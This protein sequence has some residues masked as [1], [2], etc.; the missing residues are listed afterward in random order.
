MCSRLRILAIV[1]SAVVSSFAA[2]GQGEVQIPP[3]VFK[4][5]DTFE[6]HELSKADTSFNAK[7]YR[8]SLKEYDAFIVEFPRSAAVPYAILR[9]GRSLQ[10]DDKRYDAIKQYDEIMDYFPNDVTYAAPALYYTGLAYWESADNEEA[11]KAWAEMAEDK[12]YRQHIFAADAINRLAGY[13]ASL[14]LHDKALKYFRQI[15]VDFRHRSPSAAA[16]AM[17]RV[18]AYYMQRLDEPEL[19]KF[20]QDTGTFDRF[21]KVPADLAD[22]GPYWHKVLDLIRRYGSFPDVQKSKRDEY[23]RYWVAQLGERFPADDGYRVAIINLQRIYEADET[24]WVER[25]DKQFEDHQKSDNW[26]RVLTWM[27]YLS[28]HKEK[29][30]TYYQK[31]DLAKMNYGQIVRLMSILYD[32]VGEPT[33]GRVVFGRLKLKQ[34]TDAELASLARFFWKKDPELVEVICGNMRDQEFATWELLQF[35]VAQPNVKRALEL[36]EKLLSSPTY[37]EEALWIKADLLFKEKQYKDA[38]MC[39]RQ[40]SKQPASLWQIAECYSNMGEL[41]NAVQQLREIEMF[42]K[43]PSAALRIA[44]LYQR[45]GMRA[46]QVAELRGVLK[47][48]PQ[49]GESS[50]AHRD[51]EALGER[52]GGGIDAD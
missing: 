44:K 28:A 3:D 49:T 50:Q 11:R 46:Q 41:E 9:K 22:D 51:L 52:I 48:Y 30:I 47:K 16:E 33:M 18:I 5:L 8:Q 27:E 17:A 2:L 29:V 20:Y 32:R 43:Q 25:L 40:S 35:F 13:L 6:A 12:D 14:D 45:A 4:R 21:G 19:R 15:A 38:M 34:L 23:Y 39:Y 42:F 26:N 31:L 24:K 7:N 10:L 36:A 37:A 1:L